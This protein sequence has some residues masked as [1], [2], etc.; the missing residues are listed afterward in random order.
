MRANLYNR[1][2]NPHN[3]TILISNHTMSDSSYLSES[4]P[5]IIRTIKISLDS[6]KKE[7][8]IENSPNNIYV[9][10]P[11]SS[12]AIENYFKRKLQRNSSKY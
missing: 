10:G 8:L 5:R 2:Q 9:M 11:K 12:Q 1:Q 7:E 6:L 3:R 4:I